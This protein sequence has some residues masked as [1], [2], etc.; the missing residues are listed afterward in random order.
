MFD[1]TVEAAE[2]LPVIAC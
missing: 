2:D 1:R